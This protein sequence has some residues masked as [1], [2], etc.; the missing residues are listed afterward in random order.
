MDEGVEGV[1]GV[2]LTVQQ[3]RNISLVSRLSYNIMCNA[4]RGF[5]GSEMVCSEMESLSL[6]ERVRLLTQLYPPYMQ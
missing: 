3:T 6:T 2:P 4:E 5:G 1:G